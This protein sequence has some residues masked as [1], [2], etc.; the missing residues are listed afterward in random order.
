MFRDEPDLKPANQPLCGCQVSMKW[1]YLVLMKPV[2][3]L[4]F[5]HPRSPL[6]IKPSTTVSNMFL[7]LSDG[8]GLMDPCEKEPTDALETLVLQ[9]REDITA[10][11]QV[12]TLRSSVTTGQTASAQQTHIS[13]PPP[14][15]RP[16]AARL[17]ADPQGP[18]HG[19]PA[20][21]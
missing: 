14:P 15:A 19:V 7:L 8:P 9:A 2:F 1:I 21:L 3:H 18:G 17:P 20:G 6:I 13:L 12:H 10:S 16:A 4:W 5:H 11:A